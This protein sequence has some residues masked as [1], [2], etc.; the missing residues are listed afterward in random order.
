MEL[1]DGVQIGGR[2]A[3]QQACQTGG[4]GGADH[5]AAPGLLRRPLHGDQGIDVGAVVAG[6]DH[7]APGGEQHGG[8]RLLG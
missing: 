8:R 7:M 1:V 6:R 3:A 2:E 5:E 4:R